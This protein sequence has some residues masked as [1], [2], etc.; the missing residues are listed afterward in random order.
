MCWWQWTVIQSSRRSWSATMAIAVPAAGMGE[1]PKQLASRLAPG[2]VRTGSEVV[3]VPQHS[4]TLAKGESV[5]ADAVV[6]ATDGTTAAKLLD[7]GDQA[8][9]DLEADGVSEDL[10]DLSLTIQIHAFVKFHFSH[11]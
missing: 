10:E 1:I 2:A 6:V 3:E 9:D 5:Q 8:V 11:N 7:L 4:V